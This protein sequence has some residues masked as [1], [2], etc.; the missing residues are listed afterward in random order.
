LPINLGDDV[1]SEVTTKKIDFAI[2]NAKAQLP[3]IFKPS[4]GGHK[5]HERFHFAELLL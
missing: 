4:L 2:F 5:C 3:T 1:G